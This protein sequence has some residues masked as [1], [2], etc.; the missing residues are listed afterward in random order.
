MIILS[1]VAYLIAYLAVAFV[2]AVCFS[3]LFKED[4]R[5]MA[6]LGLIWPLVPIFTFLILGRIIVEL[7]VKWV[8]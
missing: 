3:I 2:S 4:K 6:M 7:F 1:V 5:L 8:P